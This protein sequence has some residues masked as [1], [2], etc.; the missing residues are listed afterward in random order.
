MNQREWAPIILAIVF[1]AALAHG[2]FWLQ[3]ARLHDDDYTVWLTKAA[4]TSTPQCIA[5]VA[6]PSLRDWGFDR[7]P[8]EVLAIRL[9]YPVAQLQPSHYFLIKIFAFAAMIAGLCWLLLLVTGRPEP[10]L[11]L[12][13]VLIPAAPLYSS[14]LWFCDFLIFAQV[15]LVAAAG[16]FIYGERCESEMPTLGRV[17]LRIGTFL[18]YFLAIQSKPSARVFL[19]A[20][21]CYL[22]IQGWRNGIKRYWHLLG[23]M[24]VVSV[25]WVY[26]ATE[27][28]LPPFFPGGPEPLEG[29]WRHPGL[30]AWFQMVFGYSSGMNPLFSAL[31]SLAY[32]PASIISAYLLWFF[33]FA[34]LAG[35]NMVGN[36]TSVV[37][38]K[39]CWKIEVDPAERALIVLLAL[40]CLFVA[41]GFSIVP[42]GSMYDRMRFLAEFVVPMNALAVLLFWRLTQMFE[43]PKIRAAILVAAVLFYAMPN[44]AFTNHI[45]GTVGTDYIARNQIL[46]HLHNRISQA[47]VLRAGFPTDPRDYFSPAANVYEDLDPS[48]LE[49]LQQTPKGRETYVL[50][51]K[52]V[53]LPQF[54]KVW[55]ANGNAQTPYDRLV[56]LG[57][58][59]HYHNRYFIYR[60]DPDYKAPGTDEDGGAE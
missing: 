15:F 48:E 50:T 22:A 44:I 12:A 37:N 31:E 35:A 1:L 2:H 60:I 14:M 40:W 7:R 54:I 11:A 55:S 23:A 29:Q 58:A 34:A 38:L 41:I 16:L 33:V 24:F 4:N 17:G 57:N 27:S 20:F 59:S 18:C 21:A 32:P 43:G 47:T 51:K 19:L 45:R 36:Q 8:V 56:S 49:T 5:E 26:L 9:L 53:T 25:P 42:A 52:T 46:A 6:T 13:V 30:A 3:G 39:K 10:A 28:I